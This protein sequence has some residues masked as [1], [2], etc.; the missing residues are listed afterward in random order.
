MCYSGL[1]LNVETVLVLILGVTGMSKTNIT[2]EHEMKKAVIL[3]VHGNICASSYA[4][5]TVYLGWIMYKILL[6]CINVLFC[7]YTIPM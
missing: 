3:W 2:F 7:L 5:S 6:F 1:Y 4:E